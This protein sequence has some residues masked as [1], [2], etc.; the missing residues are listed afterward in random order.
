MFTIVHFLSNILYTAIY[1]YVCIYVY[2]YIYICIYSKITFYFTEKWYTVVV[3]SPM[4]FRRFLL[5][6]L[7]LIVITR[8]LPQGLTWKVATRL[9]I[10][11]VSKVVI[12]NFTE[13]HIYKQISVILQSQRG[14]S[15]CKLTRTSALS[16]YRDVFVIL[17]PWRMRGLKMM[18]TRPWVFLYI[19]LLN[20]YLEVACDLPHCIIQSDKL[21]NLSSLC[22]I[23]TDIKKHFARVI[24]SVSAFT[25]II[26]CRFGS[27]HYQQ[28]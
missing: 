26:F 21:S 19:Q 20:I 16:R 2:I 24:R 3:F 4:I 10:V 11:F 1:I 25:H 28:L 15:D 17:W 27:F 7:L 8:L 18:S 22:T 9:L 6:R 5:V 13:A 12:S 23:H 14:L